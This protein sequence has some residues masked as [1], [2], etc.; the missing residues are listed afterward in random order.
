MG[1]SGGAEAVGRTRRP[2]RR[3]ENL[4][5]GVSVATKNVSNVKFFAI[6]GATGCQGIVGPSKP[7][8]VNM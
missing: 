4:R 3:L 1:T 8:Y 2:N 6:L 7:A 5:G